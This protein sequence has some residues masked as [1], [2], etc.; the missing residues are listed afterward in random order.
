GWLY[1]LPDALGSP[2]QWVG[3]SGAI[4]LTQSYTPFG[5][6]QASAGSLSSSVGF[7]GEWA[8]PTGL[9]FL[10]ARYYQPGVGRFTTRDPFP[11]LLA[12]P[13]TLHPYLYAL[14]NP[15]QYSDPSGQLPFLALI[16]I[17]ALA[18]GGIG[19]IADYASQVH[20]NMKNC[21]MSFWDAV[22]YE[23]IDAKRLGVA[24]AEGFALGG[25]GGLTGGLVQWAGLTGLSAFAAA[26][27]LDVEAGM[28]WDLAVR[29]Y[30]PS[31]AFLTNLVSFGIGGAIGAIG[32]SAAS[33]LDSGL[34]I[35]T[36]TALPAPR[37]F[38]PDA[39]EII[40][41][42]TARDIVAYRVWGGEAKKVRAWLAPF[43]PPDRLV[44]RQVLAL[45]PENLALY[46]SEV[47]IPAGTRV[48]FS[49]AAEN[50]GLPGGAVQIQLLDQI[51]DSAFGPG[52][53]LAIALLSD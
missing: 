14:N 48:Q 10:R 9:V 42:R 21:G 53:P 24:F 26:G 12:L 3:A 17:A 45:P 40:S 32:R 51:P 11:G 46:V 18:G 36:R 25:F 4:A 52:H 49:L 29:G 44:A 7:T 30:T 35:L 50:F 33:V 20:N 22:Y 37:G 43:R 39:G 38:N 8:D 16:G 2:R 19:A 23:N 6:L 15:L 13:P 27:V 34:G 31:E 5:E 47:T 28:I 1:H 41:V